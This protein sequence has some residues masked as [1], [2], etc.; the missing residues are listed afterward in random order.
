MTDTK[1]FWLA[2]FIY[3]IVFWI[4]PLQSYWLNSFFIFLE[5]ILKNVNIGM[6]ASNFYFFIFIPIIIIIFYFFMSGIKIK[7]KHTLF[8]SMFVL[9]PYTAVFSFFFF[10]VIYA[11]IHFTP[12]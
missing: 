9:L 5:G 6:D 3:W 10:A 11:S 4:L 1:K 7:L 8:I 2:T 12:F